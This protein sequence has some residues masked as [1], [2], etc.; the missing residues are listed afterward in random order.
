VTT[1]GPE[2]KIPTPLA[3]TDGMALRGPRRLIVDPSI[4]DAVAAHVVTDHPHEA[5]GYL[6]CERRDGALHAV[7]QY[8]LDNEAE[9][10]TR[11]F[12]TT[13]E[14]DPVPEPRVFYHSH[15]ATGGPSGLTS[16]DRRL[17]EPLVLVVYAPEG[18][19]FSY[20]LFRRGL[21]N[22]REL[23]VE[24]PAGPDPGSGEPLP[25]LP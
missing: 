23:S 24:S 5:G 13:V 25:A 18:E 16:T 9:T 21:F 11:Q 10:P 14:E 6:A 12:H 19:P 7:D 15:T 2:R 20:R 1:A 8:P 22:W 17:P 4:R 3:P